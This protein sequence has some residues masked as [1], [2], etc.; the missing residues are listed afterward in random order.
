MR[1][2]VFRDQAKFSQPCEALLTEHLGSR[3]VH[4]PILVTVR[5]V[6]LQRPVGRGE[7]EKGEEW[8]VG[9]TIRQVL[10]EIAGVEIGRKEP[11]RVVGPVRFPDN[12]CSV[13]SCTMCGK[14]V[15]I[16]LLTVLGVKR[17]YALEESDHVVL[18]LGLVTKMVGAPGQEGEGTVEAALVG[19][20]VGLEA[21]VPFAA[22]ERMVSCVLQ[23]FWQR[24]NALL[25]GQVR[26]EVGQ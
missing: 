22:Q 14:S 7:G 20:I 12:S 2:D 25:T 3:I 5:F 6:Y 10:D 26:P 8:L 13:K 15:Q 1:D 18:E 21:E 11:V 17:R 9:G 19:E 16:D 23:K 4:S 24:C